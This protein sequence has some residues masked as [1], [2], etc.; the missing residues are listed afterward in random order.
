MPTCLKCSNEFPNRIVIDGKPRVLNSRK[1]CLECSPFDQHNTSK[2]H[3]QKYNK[4]C[5][6]CQEVKPIS[7][8][9]KRTNRK[10]PYTYCKPCTTIVT[11]DRIRKLK[12]QAVDYKGGKCIKCGYNKCQASLEFHHLDPSKKDFTI[13]HNNKAFKNIKSELDKCI[14]L[15]RNCHGEIHYGD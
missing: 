6:K 15:C 11:K 9:Y 8:F 5:P 1:Y 13:G 14:L 7:E 12:K 10:D 3:I 4:L 2:I